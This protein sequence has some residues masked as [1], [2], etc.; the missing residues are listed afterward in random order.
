[1]N[2]TISHEQ[3]I[4]V[5]VYFDIKKRHRAWIF[6]CIFCTVALTVALISQGWDYYILDQAHRPLAPKHSDFKPSGKIGLRLGIIG[7][8][9]VTLIYLYPLR[10]HWTVLGN[11]G[12]TKNWLDYH[13]MMGLIAPVI[14]SFHSAFKI[15]GIAGMAY[16]TM[17]AL[18]TSGLIGRYFYAQIPRSISAAEMSLKEIQDFS[19]ESME[20]LRRQKIF[21]ASEVERL[22]P[23]P[24]SSE[25][26]SM[27]V[28]RVLG[29][30]LT[31]DLVRIFKVWALR[32]RGVG[33]SGMIMTLGGILP[34]RRAELERAISLAS[35]Q[36]ALGKRIL[37]LSTT[38]R[39]FHL[40]HVI[41]RPFS[42]SF[43]ILIIIHIAVVM[44]LGY[45]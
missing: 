32:R 1:M 22:F 15:H 36:A 25:V 18:T 19:R 33:A 23:L 45:F 11:I 13:V 9:I 24:D 12:K 26:E 4:S 43:A 3:R 39:V 16:W 38:H 27:N 42:V 17:I 20:E 6:L 37:L 2:K 29:L 44:T 28:L 34:T 40:W 8:G 5:P 41:H 30:M 14:I 31:L 35:G 21:A 7:F 10:R